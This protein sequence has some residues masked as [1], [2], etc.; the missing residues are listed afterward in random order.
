MQIIIIMVII[1]QNNWLCFLVV[2]IVESYWLPES[3]QSNLYYQ[4]SQFDIPKAYGWPNRISQERKR[5][6]NV[7]ER[8][9]SELSFAGLGFKAFIQVLSSACSGLSPSSCPVCPAQCEKVHWFIST[10]WLLCG[11][12]AMECSMLLWSLYGAK[13]RNKHVGKR[14]NA[15]LV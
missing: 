2:M 15:H 10:W 14:P 4:L 9:I 1:F 11:T 13:S 6:E 7:G 3:S 5:G 8:G 12:W